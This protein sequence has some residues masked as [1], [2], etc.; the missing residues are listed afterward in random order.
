MYELGPRGYKHYIDTRVAP[1]QDLLEGE[2]F[3]LEKALPGW[4]QTLNER[5]IDWLLVPRDGPLHRALQ[6]RPG[7]R[8]LFAT[9]NAV[10]I[11]REQPSDA[12]G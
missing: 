7:W 1:F 3:V 10:V 8:E 4:E 9:D 11:R 6:E 5:Q 2:Y 12:R